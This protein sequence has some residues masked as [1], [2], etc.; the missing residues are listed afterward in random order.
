MLSKVVKNRTTLMLVTL[1]IKVAPV[2][3]KTEKLENPEVGIITQP[4][5]Q[6]LASLT[7]KKTSCFQEVFL[8]HFIQ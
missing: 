4:L 8:R 7:G 2:N 3:W 6:I 5:V 1:N